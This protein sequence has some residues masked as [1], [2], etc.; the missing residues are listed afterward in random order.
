MFQATL[1]TNFSQSELFFF[2]CQAQF[3]GILQFLCIVLLDSIFLRQHLQC[4]VIALEVLNAALFVWFITA[5]TLDCIQ[6]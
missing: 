1:I 2:F 3:L 4:S 5:L 6:H